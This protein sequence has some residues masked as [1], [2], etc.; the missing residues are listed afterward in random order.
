MMIVNNWKFST[1]IVIAFSA[2]LSLGIGSL[3]LVQYWQ[4]RISQRQ[5]MADRLSEIVQLAA[6]QVDGDYHSLVTSS[7][8]ANTTYYRINQAQLGK[9]QAASDD[10]QHL[11]TVRQQSGGQYAFVLDYRSDESAPIA[12]VGNILANPPSLLASG[13]VI[14]GPTVEPSIVR[15]SADIPVLTGYAPIFGQ[16]NRIDGLL[17]VELDARP[18]LQG[19]LQAERIAIAALVT[20]LVIMV[21]TVR[22]LAQA[23]VVRPTRMLNQAAKRLAEGDWTAPLPT[24]RKDELGELAQSFHH[25]AQHLQHSFQQLEDYSQNL[26]EKV[27]VRTQALLESQQA[28]QQASAAK[29]EFLANMNHELRTPL[30]GILGYTQ[31]LQRDL[32][33]QSK[34]QKGLSTIHQ[35]ASH[36][37]SLINDILDFSKLEVQKMELSEQDF[38][39]GDF[40][41][42]T[43]DM[44]RI[45]AE[46]KEVKLIYESSSALPIAVYADDKRLRQVLI[47]LIGNAAK[48]TDKGKVTFRV[49]TIQSPTKHDAPWRLR[50]EIEDTGIGID[51]NK[52]AKIFSP[53]EQAGERDRNAEGTG[54]GLAI[55]RR[56]VQMM[57]G[58]IQVKSEL[59]KGSLFWFEIDLSAAREWTTNPGDTQTLATNQLVINNAC[60][61][62][63]SEDDVVPPAAELVTLYAAAKDGFM[64]EVQQEA[65]RLKALDERYVPFADKLL[66]L[67]HQFNDK[68]LLEL[69][70]PIVQE[71]LIP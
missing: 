35:C 31:I 27:E 69:I 61:Y 55:S 38:H 53:F 22:Y 37:L 63:P 28:A 36:L 26:E 71:T 64:A 51:Q 43:V 52:L 34:H 20:I 11:Y 14:N 54:L 19:E 66:A 9:I 30:N 45:K 46:Q 12:E 7:Q 47:N 8:D 21:V 44:C 17:V 3:A 2:L 16:F 29:S 13:K 56:I 70:Q 5:A 50:F 40:L 60:N 1:K 6:P 32:A 4:L 10:I 67:S 62:L 49:K 65:T 15:N 25:M 58:D 48:F 18:I 68:A 42:S 23:L 33:A 39:L 57:G 41:R 24:T 59:G